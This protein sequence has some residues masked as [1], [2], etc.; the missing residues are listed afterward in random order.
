MDGAIGMPMH[1]G[2]DF[3]QF[4]GKQ[5]RFVLVD[6]RSSFDYGCGKSDLT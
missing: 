6:G 4:I 2:M 5:F 3:E 1:M